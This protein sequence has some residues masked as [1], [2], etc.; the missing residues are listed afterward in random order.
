MLY[1]W[2]RSS[3]DYVRFSTSNQANQ[4]CHALIGRR[5]LTAVGPPLRSLF[6]GTAKLTCQ[7]AP[8]YIAVY[9]VRLEKPSLL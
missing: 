3:L 2:V 6:Q 9:Q 5:Q 4:T 8:M 7:V 1:L